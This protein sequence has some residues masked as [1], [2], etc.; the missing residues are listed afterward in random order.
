M[1]AEVQKFREWIK[2]S[3]DDNEQL[4]RSNEKLH[5]E[6]L[7]HRLTEK[8]MSTENEEL[9]SDNVHLRKQVAVLE[10][11]TKEFEGIKFEARKLF[12][13]KELLQCELDET[14][15]LTDI[16]KQQAEEAWKALEN[17]RELRRTLQRQIHDQSD[18]RD[19]W[20]RM[21]SLRLEIDEEGEFYDEQCAV[22]P[23]TPQSDNLFAELEKSSAEHGLQLSNEVESYKQRV[24]QISKIIAALEV[25][26]NGSMLADLKNSVASAAQEV[27][28]LCQNVGSSEH[29]AFLDE[30]QVQMGK[31]NARQTAL[32]SKISGLVATVEAVYEILA[33]KQLCIN[34]C[35]DSLRSL[36][37]L[38]NNAS[39]ATG[40]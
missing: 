22:V 9:H 40:G 4:R 25:L 39:S 2:A 29:S 5:R 37:G 3:G 10:L 31:K 15:R 11:R 36:R 27:R 38:L 23:Q 21:A 1:A 19:R 30:M 35:F 34:T 13:D 33:E 20:N 7:D 24:A 14:R 28:G 16:V 12:E 17:E 26:S 6:L 18:E 8:V 32:E